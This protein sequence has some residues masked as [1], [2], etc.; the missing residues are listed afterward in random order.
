MAYWLYCQA[1][2]QWSKSATPLSD[3]KSCSFCNSLL[4]KTKQPTR[5]KSENVPVEIPIEP[6]SESIIPPTSELPTDLDSS[7][8][9]DEV[10]IV[11]QKA[12]EVPESPL[13]SDALDGSEK[14]KDDDI[15]EEPESA[16]ASL[17]IAEMPNPTVKP[18]TLEP[19]ENQEGMDL[20]PTAE[21]VDGSKEPIDNETSD[22]AEEFRTDETLETA[23]PDVTSEIPIAPEAVVKF[24]TSKI[25]EEF[26]SSDTLEEIE[27][28]VPHEL[29]GVPSSPINT[30]G[31]NA[32]PEFTPEE[33]IEEL[34]TDA[35]PDSP[36]AIEVPTEEKISTGAEEHL[37]DE[38]LEY[39]EEPAE[40]DMDEPSH[41]SY[42]PGHRMFLEDK[43]RRRKR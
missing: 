12:L 35:T 30:E 6:E 21:L 17:L 23:D 25:P 36:E 40:D 34:E 24:D 8:N 11:E 9:S 28:P 38:S 1:C 32:L 19:D 5:F 18:I 43:R 10:Q 13:I 4:V 16:E 29:S 22:T 15:P 3:N 26:E 39:P 14:L 41:P 20:S 37:A 7:D 31:S 2:K 33:T 27:R 42:T